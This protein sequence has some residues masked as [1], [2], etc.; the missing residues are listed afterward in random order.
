MR[1]RE[2]MTLDFVENLLRDEKNHGPVNDKEI[3]YEE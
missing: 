2:T 1:K 3:Y